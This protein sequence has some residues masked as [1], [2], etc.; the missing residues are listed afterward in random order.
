[1]AG[2]LAVVRPRARPAAVADRCGRRARA[3]G[4][5]P[6]RAGLAGPAVRLPGASAVVG[7]AAAS[8]PAATPTD[9]RAAERRGRPGA[10]AAVVDGRARPATPAVARA[11]PGSG[12]RR[13]SGSW[14][15]PRSSPSRSTTRPPPP[16]RCGPRPPRSAG[17]S[18]RSSPASAAPGSCCGCP[19]DALDRVIDDIAAL[20]TV[21]ARSPARSSTPPRRS[22]TSTPACASQQAS[23]DRVRALLAQ[24]TS[25]GDVVADRVGAGPPRG[26]AGL[27]D[28]R[29]AALRDQV[30]LSTLTVDLRAPAPGAGRGRR[31]RR[32]LRRAGWPRAGPGCS[33]WARPLAAVVGFLLPFL[34]VLAVLAGLGWVVRRSLRAR[35]RAAAG[36]GVAAGGAGAASGAGAAERPGIRGGVLDR[37]APRQPAGR[38]ARSGGAAGNLR[39]RTATRG[40]RRSDRT[41]E[42]V[43]APFRRHHDDSCVTARQPLGVTPIGCFDRRADAG[44]IAA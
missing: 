5:R 22:S 8:S 36:S 28:R 27:A 26:R 7:G 12:R 39:C 14:C 9:D 3:A 18:S 31:A 40:H 44:G 11:G 20:G 34:P 4:R 29:L 19:A 25:I 6:R 15:A 41:G 23:V 38:S 16:G 17:S 32:R 30:A 42:V 13:R 21:T 10:G 35:R 43:A 33:R 24:A 2:R 37:A 1:M